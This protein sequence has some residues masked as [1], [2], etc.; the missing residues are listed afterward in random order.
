VKKDRL[1]DRAAEQQRSLAL[2]FEHAEL[3][4]EDLWLRYFGVGGEAGFI[5]VDAYVNGLSDLPP[6]ERDTLV[7]IELCRKG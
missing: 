3:S 5:D 6:L 4:V 7:E 2:A 1:P